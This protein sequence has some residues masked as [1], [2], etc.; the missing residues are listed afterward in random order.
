MSRDVRDERLGERVHE[1]EIG[2]SGMKTQVDVF[3]FGRHVAIDK[4]DGIGTVVGRGVDVN[5][6]H[7]LVPVDAS[8]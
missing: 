5:L 7:L 1:V 3:A 4:G 6:L 8:Q 2:T